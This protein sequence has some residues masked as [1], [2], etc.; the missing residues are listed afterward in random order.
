M[1]PKANKMQVK[2]ITVK[3]LMGDPFAAWVLQTC[4]N[5]K[6]VVFPALPTKT[7]ATGCLGYCIPGGLWGLEMWQA[8][9]FALQQF[10]VQNF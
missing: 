7:D 5:G 10:L 2:E 3:K 9:A 8:P 1:H 4:G 6:I